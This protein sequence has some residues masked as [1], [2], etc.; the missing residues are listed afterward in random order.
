MQTMVYAQL[1]L[2]ETPRKR[3]LYTSPVDTLICLAFPFSK[4]WNLTRA[5]VAEARLGVFHRA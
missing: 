3:V 5:G 4:S 1:V 2:T